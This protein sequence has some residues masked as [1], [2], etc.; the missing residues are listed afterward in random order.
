MYIQAICYSPL[1]VC[2]QLATWVLQHIHTHPPPVKWNIHTLNTCYT[3]H[4]H[5]NNVLQRIYT[6][7]QHV[8][9]Y[10]NS[11]RGELPSTYIILQ[12]VF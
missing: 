3:E 5:T 7:Q 2:V 11:A 1:S 4:T 12:D 9:A 8:A 6:H 10:I